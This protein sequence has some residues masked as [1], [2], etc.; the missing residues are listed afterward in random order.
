MEVLTI[1]YYYSDLVGAK[2]RRDSTSGQ[3]LGDR[4]ELI[5]LS[6][7]IIIIIGK[8]IFCR[9]KFVYLRLCSLQLPA[10]AHILRRMQ[11]E[12]DLRLIGYAFIYLYIERLI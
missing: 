8:T 2:T 12:R 9:C 1:S 5:L 3:E 4:E 6:A 10:T 7:R 11:S